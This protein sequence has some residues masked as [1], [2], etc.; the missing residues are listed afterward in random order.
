MSRLQVIEELL[1]GHRALAG[2]GLDGGEI[3]L[4]LPKCE[5]DPT[6]ESWKNGC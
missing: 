5:P 4:I 3:L 6:V 1:V 2:A